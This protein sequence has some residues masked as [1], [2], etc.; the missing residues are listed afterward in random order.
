[1]S[2]KQQTL[3]IYND[4]AT[5]EA[6]ERIYNGKPINWEYW[7]G[8]INI[9][10]KQAAKLAHCINPIRWPDNVIAQG[11]LS[12][13]LRIKI[14]SLS[15]LLAERDQSWALI[16]L[17]AYLGELAP[18]RMKLVRSLAEA[19]EITLSAKRK[20]EAGR[21]T[22][23]EA[24]NALAKGF[25]IDPDRWPNVIIEAIENE[26]IPLKNPRNPSDNIPYAFPKVLRPWY[27][28]VLA[29]DINKWLDEH[30]DYGP[31]RLV[32]IQDVDESKKDTVEEEEEN[33][34]ILDDPQKTK[35]S[36][37]KTISTNERHST[38][39][40]VVK[41]CQEDAKN[42]IERNKCKEMS[43]R[44]ARL[45]LADNKQDNPNR[46]P[47]YDDYFEASQPDV[48]RLR[49]TIRTTLTNKKLFVRS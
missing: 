16:N 36:T 25:G 46:D 6:A 5:C 8:R 28:Q 41:K 4:E 7:S 1:M 33:Q 43:E 42:R 20:Q 47:F 32:D 45:I 44:A 27:D 14:Q 34:I 38:W 21:Y 23:K 11:P 40:K 9:S 12:E 24:A 31:Y 18:Y 30:P 10:P 2:D 3:E 39:D 48:M 22:L 17:I 15:E 26:E 13:E 49:D 29:S 19:T 37:E 35:K